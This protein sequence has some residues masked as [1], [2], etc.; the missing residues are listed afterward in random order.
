MAVTEKPSMS[1]YNL[2]YLIMI[3]MET[4]VNL[5]SVGTDAWQAAAAAAAGPLLSAMVTTRPL[6]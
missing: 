3:F 4:A 6:I 2:N 1:R 5:A